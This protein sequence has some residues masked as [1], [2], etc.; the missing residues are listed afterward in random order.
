MFNK[1]KH[2]HDF[3]FI[4]YIDTYAFFLYLYICIM[5]KVEYQNPVKAQSDN[6]PYVSIRP[7]LKVLGNHSALLS[8]VTSYNPRFCNSFQRQHLL[9]CCRSLGAGTEP[10]A[11]RAGQALYHW[12]YN[13]FILGSDIEFF[14]FLIQHIW[15]KE[16]NF[17]EKWRVCGYSSACSPLL[18]TSNS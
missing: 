16:K 2:A 10:R 4:I 8:E 1:A 11:S 14:F 12:I 5:Y 18:P 17:R 7:P 3:S 9:L 13:V 15:E 6:P